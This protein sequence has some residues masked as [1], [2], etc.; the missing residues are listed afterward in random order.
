MM[1]YH[2]VQC[3]SG[4]LLAWGVHKAEGMQYTKAIVVDIRLTYKAPDKGW[5]TSVPPFVCSSVMWVECKN[6]MRSGILLSIV[7][8]CGLG[9]QKLRFYLA[10]PPFKRRSKFVPEAEGC[11]YVQQEEVLCITSVIPPRG[12]ID[13]SPY[14]AQVRTSLHI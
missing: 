3:D 7:D 12:V 5:V 8:M 13:L 6:N 2:E 14:I 10:K 9:I 4:S 1:P 11:I